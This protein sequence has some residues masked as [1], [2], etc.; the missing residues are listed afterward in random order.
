MSNN[1]C[2]LQKIFHRV[3]F[4]IQE[5]ADF[6]LGKNLAFERVS[7]FFIYLQLNFPY[8]SYNNNYKQRFRLH[9]NQ[10][11]SWLADKL[12]ASKKRLRHK[13]WMSCCCSQHVTII[14]SWLNFSRSGCEAQTIFRHEWRICVSKFALENV[15]VAWLQRRMSLEQLAEMGNEI[16][17]STFESSFVQV[18]YITRG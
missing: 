8:G 17:H 12:S 10:G 15:T 13:E 6:F 9:K 3:S 14:V 16:I 11:I 5:R 1:F 2:L 4:H 7:T 18:D